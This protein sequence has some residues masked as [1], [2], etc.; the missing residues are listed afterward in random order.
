MENKF[1][2]WIY[3]KTVSRINSDRRS[4]DNEW[5]MVQIDN[6]RYWK[7][8]QKDQDGYYGYLKDKVTEGQ[9]LDAIKQAQFDVLTSII[10]ERKRSKA[11]KA[12]EV[13]EDTIKWHHTSDRIKQ[14][15]LEEA[16]RKCK[17]TKPIFE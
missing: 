2:E 3:N 8:Y 4:F 5:V 12:K 9:A 1:Q 15:L 17:A 11:E 14:R 16:M 13:A 6:D 10:E 7:L